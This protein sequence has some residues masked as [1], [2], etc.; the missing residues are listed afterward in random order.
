MDAEGAPRLVLYSALRTDSEEPVLVGQFCDS[1]E[2]CRSRAEQAAPAVNYSFFDGSDAQGWEGYGIADQGMA[3]DQCRVEVQV[4]T[5]TASS[6]QSIQIDT[7]GVEVVYP[8]SYEDDVATCTIRDAIN[9]LD[10]DSPCTALFLL[11]ATFEA[12]L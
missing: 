4:H 6:A 7:E 5:L 12:G 3:G 11:E 9:W 10:E 1:V 2:N 8:P